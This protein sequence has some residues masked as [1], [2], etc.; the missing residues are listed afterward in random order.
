[1]VDSSRSLLP[2][3]IIAAGNL[4]RRDSR[5]V[6]IT[7]QAIDW[8]G[9]LVEAGQ[10]DIAQADDAVTPNHYLALNVDTTPLTIEVKEPHGFKKIVVPPQT[11]WLNPGSSPV[12]LRT[13]NR[14]AYVRVALDPLHLGRLIHPVPD[15][16][17]PVL[18]RRRYAVDSPQIA[19][20]VLALAA[21]ADTPSGGLATV[22]AV[23][24]ALGH[25][26][27][28]HAGVATRPSLAQALIHGGLSS[29]AKRRALEMIDGLLDAHL[30]VEMLAREVGLSPAHFA[31]AF[32]Q[33]MGRAPHQYLLALRLERARRLLETTRATLSDIAQRAGFADQAHFT[34]LFKRAFGTTPGALV[35]HLH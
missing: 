5:P 30:T 34:R 31:R 8:P 19:H 28:H 17:A 1:M 10:N 27:V 18:L 33:T 26:L 15:D 9:V 22:E 16:V 20:L 6:N 4:T 32:K 7:T 24:T 29:A 11:F 25:L 14:N 35:R 12:T 23:T 13:E 3:S 21:E 2:Q